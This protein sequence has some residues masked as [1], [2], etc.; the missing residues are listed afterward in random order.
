MHRNGVKNSIAFG[1]RVTKSNALE[2]YQD[3]YFNQDAYFRGGMGIILDGKLY[4]ITLKEVN[5][6]LVLGATEITTYKGE[7]L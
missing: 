4:N 3:A 5:G 1:G 6:E 7:E 2:V